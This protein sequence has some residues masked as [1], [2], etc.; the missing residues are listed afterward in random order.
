[1]LLLVH[2]TST[3]RTLE[4]HALLQC[5]LIGLHLPEV[6]FN[7]T[8]KPSRLKVSQ[9]LQ[10]GLTENTETQSCSQSNS[11]QVSTQ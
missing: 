10:A 3:L 1:M 4:N 8:D 7:R 6:Y 9:L 2:A 11:S 5:L